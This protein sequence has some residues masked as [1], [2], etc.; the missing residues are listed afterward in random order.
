VARTAKHRPHKPATLGARL[1]KRGRWWTADLRP[2]GGRRY[3]SLRNPNDPNWPDAG[4]RTEDAEVAA[5][6][7]WSY[8]SSLRGEAT[9]R[10]LGRPKRLALGKAIAEYRVHRDRT[11]GELTA[12]NEQAILRHMEQ[13]YGGKVSVHAITTD[14]VQEM[15]DALL[16]EGFMPST[17][18]TRLAQLSAFFA[19]TGG[20]N[21][22]RGVA[23]PAVVSPED[24]YAWTDEDIQALRDAADELEGARVPM[25]LL[26]ELALATGARRGE[27]LALQWSDF[28]PDTKTVRIVRQFRAR[29]TRPVALKGK[30][31]RTALVLPSLWP[32]YRPED[33]Y[34]I[35]RDGKP[36]TDVRIYWPVHGL[37]VAAGVA[38]P[39]RGIHDARRTYGRLFLE[40]G[41]WMDELQRS[42][43]HGSIRVTERQYGRFQAE[44]AAEFARLRIYGEGRARRLS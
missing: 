12:E 25:R 3:A 29:T 5:R 19:W 4:E 42:L 6:W 7:M 21:P 30:K 15:L 39:Q 41:G 11:V 33:G 2:F 10:Q 34:C 16:D 1:E 14:A 8:V 38:G 32:H 40:A 36:I 44:R 17:V 27:L 13:T 18:H 20:A 23:L 28:S 43:G 31:A 37:L 26:L 9:D 24:P 22:C 35:Q